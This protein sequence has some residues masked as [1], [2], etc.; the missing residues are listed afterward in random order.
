MAAVC[1]VGILF[2]DV[3]G[4]S[5]IYEQLGDTRAHAVINQCFRIMGEC[6]QGHRGVVVKTIGDELMAAFSAAHQPFSCAMDIRRRFAEMPA[7][8][9]SEGEIRVAV[10]IGFHFGS[11]MREQ[12]DFFGD[13]V[14]IAARMVGLAKASH[15][16]T[17][18]DVMDLLPESQRALAVEFGEIEVRGRAGPVR[19][20]QI[21]VDAP[22]QNATVLRFGQSSEAVAAGPEIKLIFED[23][24]WTVPSSSRSIVFGRDPA[25]DL[26]LKS[27]HVSRSH[28]TI[29][30]RR[31][32]FFLVDHSTNGTS[33]MI[34]AQRP[35]VL[36]REEFGLVESGRIAFG[37]TPTA[38]GD[39][40]DFLIT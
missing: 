13:T 11:A 27:P 35:I 12:E 2:A 5:R 22:L 21:P 32:K 23:R 37:K 4:S 1:E 24:E 17:T 39:I 34:G 29:E 8:P 6:V 3:V 10:R 33:L 26:I 36:L 38:D 31:D 20:A 7:L 25:S 18:G 15:I 16:L 19:I 40:V 14:N 9:L 30:R 28:A